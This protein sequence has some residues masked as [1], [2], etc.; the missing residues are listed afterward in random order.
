MTDEVIPQLGNSGGFYVCDLDWGD[1][2]DIENPCDEFWS[3]DNKKVYEDYKLSN[4]KL[5]PSVTVT[6][7]IISPLKL[8]TGVIISSALV[9]ESEIG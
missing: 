8:S 7:T 1:E 3:D 9:S 5:F 4:E 6:V 2:S